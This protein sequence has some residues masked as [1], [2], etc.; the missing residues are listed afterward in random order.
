MASDIRD[1]DAWAAALLNS[2]E[3]TGRRM[4]ARQIAGELRRQQQA[5]IAAQTNPDGT[6]YEPRKPQM[7]RKAGRVKR[8]MFTKIRTA[9]YLKIEATSDS[10]VVKFTGEVQ[11]IARV[12]HFGLRD[13]VER[14]GPS[15]Q[16]AARE[17][18]GITDSDQATIADL[19]IKHVAR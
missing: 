15:V 9:R 6:P 11:R 3:P 10:A 1:L 14:N 18:L 4:L 8:K 16:Y 19:I 2:L 17:L 13:R 5:R 12:H 7:R